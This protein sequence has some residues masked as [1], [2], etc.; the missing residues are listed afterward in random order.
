MISCSAAWSLKPG[1]RA[2]RRCKESLES[3]HDS[4]CVFVRGESGGL[5]FLIHGHMLEPGPGASGSRPAS[6]HAS[7]ALGSTSYPVRTTVRA[8]PLRRK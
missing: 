3:Q 5:S 1:Q 6:C 8:K 2:E 7:L 4:L